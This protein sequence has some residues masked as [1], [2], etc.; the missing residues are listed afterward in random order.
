[1]SMRRLARSGKMRRL[2]TS[3]SGKSSVAL[4]PRFPRTLL[5]KLHAR[6]RRRYENTATPSQM[7]DSSRSTPARTGARPTDAHRS[8]LLSSRRQISGRTSRQRS[9]SL[10]EQIKP[11][12]RQPQ[13]TTIS[14][15]RQSGSGRQRAETSHSPTLNSSSVT[16]HDQTEAHSLSNKWGGTQRAQLT[17]HLAHHTSSGH[18]MGF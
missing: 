17:E 10:T 8:H 14:A 11:C 7:K 13:P 3:A 1:M 2:P 18:T 15:P 9:C 6:R 16:S 12:P 5:L 4:T